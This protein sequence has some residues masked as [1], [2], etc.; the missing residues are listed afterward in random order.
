M[1]NRRENVIRMMITELITQREQCIAN[2]NKRAT[3]KQTKRN[4]NGS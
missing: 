3:E 2:I 1:M 4:E